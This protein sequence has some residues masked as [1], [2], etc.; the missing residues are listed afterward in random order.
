[1]VGTGIATRV[2]ESKL[3]EEK[4]KTTRFCGFALNFCQK[5][6]IYI[7]KRI[8]LSQDVVWR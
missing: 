7:S 8:V 1:M 2:F 6:P 4:G 5:K 3:V